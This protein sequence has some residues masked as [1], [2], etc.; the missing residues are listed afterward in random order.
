M[1]V[2]RRSF[3]MMAVAGAAALYF[4]GRVKGGELKTE[5]KMK[6]NKVKKGL[7]VWYSQTGNTKR[8]GKLIA[9]TW[10]KAGIAT[11][12]GD[13]RKLGKIN[14]ADYDV[15]AMGSPVHYNEVPENF[16]EWIKGISKIDG[17]P[18]ASF[19]TFGGEGSNQHNTAYSIL[20]MLSYKG[21]VSVGMAL[22]GAMSSFAPTWSVGNVDRILKYKDQP[23]KSVY[24]R[25]RRYALDILADIQNGKISEASKEFSFSDY[26]SGGVSIGITKLLITDH[27]VNKEKCIACGTCVEN[28]PVKAIFPDK[29]VVDTDRCIACLGCVNNCPAEAVEMRFMGKNV[30]GFNEF[31]K[32]NKIR[33]IEP[34]ELKG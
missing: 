5:M 25:V 2:T 29:G 9:A 22:F 18:V 24:S 19:V 17:T 11:D 32:R 27:H 30:Y 26:L 10:A 20:E 23:D 28:C 15:I 16:R 8:I 6:T 12:S 1:K 21:G 4:P 13:Y 31:L 3:A 34:E 33:V 7:V 14:P